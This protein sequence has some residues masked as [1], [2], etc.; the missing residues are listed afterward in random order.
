[1]V[2]KGLNKEE[3]INNREK[4]GTNEINIQKR[5]NFQAYY[6]NLQVIRLLKFY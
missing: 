3:V 2:N 4:Y 5:K 6:Q 1:M